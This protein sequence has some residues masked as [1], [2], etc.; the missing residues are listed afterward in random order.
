M[1]KRKKPRPGVTRDGGGPSPATE[2]RVVFS[3]HDLEVPPASYYANSVR[4]E[5]TSMGVVFMF[6]QMFPRQSEIGSALCVEMSSTSFE[7]FVGTLDANFRSV[8]ARACEPYGPM[9]PYPA[10]PPRSERPGQLIPAHAAR[11]NAHDAACVID[12]FELTFGKR[13]SEMTMNSA[14]RIRCLPPIIGHVVERSD[15]LLTEARA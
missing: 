8:L 5:R 2:K 12:F 6:A 7:Q 13:A 15:A 3:A 1:A 11:I 4:L 9:T 14:L 10:E